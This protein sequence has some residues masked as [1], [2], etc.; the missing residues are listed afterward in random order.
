[1]F[2]A[3]SGTAYINAVFYG[4]KANDSDKDKDGPSSSSSGCAVPTT[5]RKHILQ[6][7]TYQ[8]SVPFLT[9]A[10]ELLKFLISIYRCAFCC[11]STIGMYWLTMTY[12]R[13]RIYPHVNWFVHCNRC[14]WES[15]H[16]V[17]SC[18][19]QKRKQKTLSPRMSFMWTMHLSPNSIGTL[20][21]YSIRIC[22]LNTHFFVRAAG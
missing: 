1:M 4:R 20:F 6:V 7:S 17:C 13:R 22:Y 21:E 14:Q 10:K 19:I 11:C 5:T 15:R 2:L 18:A 16:S 8:V 9:A 12:N 3:R